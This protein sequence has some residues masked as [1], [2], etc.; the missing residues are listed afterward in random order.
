MALFKVKSNQPKP[1][2]VLQAISVW[3]LNH[4]LIVISMSPSERE[5]ERVDYT[6][7]NC[8]GEDMMSAGS[9]GV[10]SGMMLTL[11]CFLG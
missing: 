1:N 11:L 3:D 5:R 6:C 2:R 8:L 10:C 7:Q 9:A 4:H